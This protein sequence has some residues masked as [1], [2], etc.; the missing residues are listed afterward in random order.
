MKDKRIVPIPPATHAKILVAMVPPLCSSTLMRSFNLPK[1]SSSEDM[2]YSCKWVCSTKLMS[3]SSFFS[4]SDNLFST[5]SS[6][7]SCPPSTLL[8]SYAFVPLRLVIK[9]M[10][11]PRI[12]QTCRTVCSERFCSNHVITWE[13]WLVSHDI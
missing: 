11:F 12:K 8:L 1:F 4:I 13:R 10:I 7:I 6:F 9:C 3:L 5:S 2:R